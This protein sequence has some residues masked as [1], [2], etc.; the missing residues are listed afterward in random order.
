MYYKNFAKIYDKF[1]KYCDY[2][3]W[4]ELVEENVRNSNVKGKKL[5]D[6]GCGTGE[7]LK[8]LCKNF[9]CSGLDLS[10]GMLTVANKKLKGK[11]VKLFLGDMR[12]F[13]TGERYDII[14]SLFDTVN[15]LTS[16]EDLNDLMKNIK[17][18]LN[19]EG[20]FIFDIITENFIKE[21]FPGEIFFDD[22]DDMCVIWEHYKDEEIDVIDAI[23]FVKN[24]KG[25]YKKFNET[26]E[27][28]VFTKDE[29]C[30]IIEKNKLNLLCI[31]KNDRIAGERFLY[32]L[33]NDE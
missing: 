9:E 23:Y 20:I 18:V 22:R 7:M 12:E 8:R 13:D 4:V 33:K 32:V 26:Y 10:E 29:I 24:K 28:R 2:D 11:K 3:E 14:I 21:M 5:L 6:L 15:H 31:S 30:K 16:L 27:K 19:S 25:D 17:K 1:M